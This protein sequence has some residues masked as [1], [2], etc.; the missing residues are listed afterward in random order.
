VPP[1]AERLNLLLLLLEDEELPLELEPL[2]L[3]SSS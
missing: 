3:S 1:L 2:L